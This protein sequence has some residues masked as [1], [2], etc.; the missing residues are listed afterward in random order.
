MAGCPDIEERWQLYRVLADP[1][2]LR[3]L[4]LTA[5]EELSIGEVS[6]L[7]EQPQP[8]VSRHVS[9]LRDT[10]LV[11]TRRQGKR[12]MARSVAI[13][14]NDAVVADALAAGR[15]L[16]EAEGILARIH[17]VVGARDESGRAFFERSDHSTR[18]TQLAEELPSYGFAIACLVPNRRL[19]VDVGTGDGSLLDLLAPIFDTVIAV[20]RSEVQL[21]RARARAKSRGYDNVRVLRDEVGGASLRRVVGSGA[22]LVV[23]ARF[24]HHAPRPREAVSELAALVVPGGALTLIDYERHED[25]SMREEQADVWLGFESDELK[26]F[27]LD[28]GLDAPT[29]RRIPSGLS[30]NSV[31]GHLA[32][33]VLNA[34]KPK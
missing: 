3:V 21:G 2:R 34:T 10:G 4:A 22:D 25:E 16:C 30:R 29:V 17:Q 18:H 1:M 20:D 32:W 8:N 23:A 15:R 11:E 12:V 6:E 9:L 19:A 5:A 14:L 26:E 27:A 28:A 33:L 7:L 13:A 31:D 24:L